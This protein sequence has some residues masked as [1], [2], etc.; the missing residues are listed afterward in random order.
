MYSNGVETIKCVVLDFITVSTGMA[1]I[2]CFLKWKLLFILEDK[3][4]F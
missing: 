2:K 1:K 3:D 4:A